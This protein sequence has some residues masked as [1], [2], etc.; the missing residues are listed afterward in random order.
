[1][2]SDA[3]FEHFRHRTKDEERFEKLVESAKCPLIPSRDL[4][5]TSTLQKSAITM[6]R[7]VER[8]G[9]AYCLAV[10]AERRYPRFGRV[11]ASDASPFP[12]DQSSRPVPTRLKKTPPAWL[13][14]ARGGR[15][16]RICRT[17]ASI[18]ACGPQPTSTD[19]GSISAYA[20][21]F[22]RAC[23]YRAARAEHEIVSDR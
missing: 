23:A 3:I 4:R 14:D 11:F 17:R 1:M 2:T 9:D 16:R 12:N 22:I 19:D 20:C 21:I 10:F 6:Q 7:D 18:R 5:G 13:R 8:Y 15:R